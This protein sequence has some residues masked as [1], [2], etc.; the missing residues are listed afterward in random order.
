MLTILKIGGSC[1]TYKKEQKPQLRKGFLKNLAKAIKHYK[2]KER[3][4]QLVLVHGGGSITH[5]LLDKYNIAQ[6]LKEGTIDQEK[7]L[8]ATSKIHLAMSLLNKR[9]LQSLLKENIPAWPIQTS[10]ITTSSK[11]K[12]DTIFFKS[13]LLALEKGFIPIIHGDLNIDTCTTNSICSGDLIACLLAKKL[14]AKR[15]LFASD[16]DGIYSNDPRYHKNIVLI[17]NFNIKST[18]QH[19]NS[20]EK[21]F[22]HS[23]G[24]IGKLKYIKEFCDQGMEI[25]IFNGLRKDNFNTALSRKNIGTKV[26]W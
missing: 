20:A 14:K 15:L 23:G 19:S 17:R 26:S 3:S 8:L 2:N 21:E 11:R 25:I 9:I 6:K 13:T 7:D 16:V 18:K 12:I 10:A 1:L 24:M 4:N 22:D 5:P